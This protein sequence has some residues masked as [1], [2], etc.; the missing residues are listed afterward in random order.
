MKVNI[1]EAR[2]VFEKKV[3]KLTRSVARQFPIRDGQQR[4]FA[5]ENGE[6]VDLPICKVLGKT[7]GKRFMKWL[8]LVED[9]VSGYAWV[10]AH[11]PDEYLVKVI[12]QAGGQTDDPLLVPTVVL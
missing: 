1:L 5:L 2:L 11:T 7:L 8:Y 10:P 9:P 12:E 6:R 3:V 4:A